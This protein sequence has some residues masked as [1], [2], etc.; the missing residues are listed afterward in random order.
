MC[1]LSVYPFVW[2]LSGL[3]FNWVNDLDTF[4]ANNPY[5]DLNPQLLTF[6]MIVIDLVFLGLDTMGTTRLWRRSR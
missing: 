3:V 1:Q 6:L 5:P 4:S 2:I